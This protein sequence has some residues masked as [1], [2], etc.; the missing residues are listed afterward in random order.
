MQVLDLRVVRRQAPATLALAVSGASASS[1]SAVSYASALLLA[2]IDCSRSC[3]DLTKALAPSVCS[4]RRQR[5][6][7]D[8]GLAERGEH[9][10]AVAAVAGSTPPTLP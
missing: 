5:V 6:D 9:R 3:H 4:C 2:S 8:A 1:G 7:V 10:L